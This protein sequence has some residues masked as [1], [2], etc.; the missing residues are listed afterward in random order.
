MNQQMSDQWKNIL[1]DIK[2]EL[3]PTSYL[4]VRESKIHAIQSDTMVIS[5]V[6]EFVRNKIMDAFLPVFLGAIQK[7]FPEIQNLDFV[8]EEPVEKNSTLDTEYVPTHERSSYF[9]NPESVDSLPLNPRYTFENFIVGSN[10]QLAYAG[11]KSIT[12]DL[13]KVYN[14]LFLYGGVG[15]GKTHLL[16]AIAH[17]CNESGNKNIVY[18]TSEQFLNQVVHSIQVNTVDKFRENIRRV[19]YLIIDDIQFLVGKERTQEELFHTFNALYDQKKQIA[20]SSDRPQNELKGIQERLISRFSMGLTVDIYP[21]DYETR[22]AILR[23]K[24]KAEQYDLPDE[25]LDFIASQQFNNIR[26]LEGSLIRVASYSSMQNIQNVTV[27][28]AKETLKNF[29]PLSYKKFTPEEIK[30]IVADFYN[31]K[32]QILE[33]K[34]RSKDVAVPRQVAI[35]LIREM[36]NYSLPVIGRYFGGRDHS[37]IIH[38]YEKIKSEMKVDPKLKNEVEEIIKKLQYTS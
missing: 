3:V 19:D 16:Q 5:V 27:D 1:K 31:T 23:N 22:L 25:V 32:P 33:S 9:N 38:S 29:L 4:A 2:K 35:Y 14:P 10:N 24:D 36:T 28:F 20:I 30:V 21:P 6:S 11:C 37:T 15:L 26:Q 34:R 18:I 13:G 7:Q 12:S 17:E 8:V